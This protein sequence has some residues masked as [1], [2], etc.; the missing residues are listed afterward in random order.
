M[1]SGTLR[2]SLQS[3]LLYKLARLPRTDCWGAQSL[4]AIFRRKIPS[5]PVI[6]SVNQFPSGLQSRI[7]LAYCHA[8]IDDEAASSTACRNMAISL[9]VVAQYSAGIAHFSILLFH[10]SLMAN[11]D[12]FSREKPPPPRKKQHVR[13][14]F[15]DIRASIVC[16]NCTAE[17]KCIGALLADIGF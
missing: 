12:R 14:L 7:A 13:I 10:R 11:M 1:V 9:S 6:A 3:C 17:A 16:N 4:Y 15:F 8:A 5:T 2:D